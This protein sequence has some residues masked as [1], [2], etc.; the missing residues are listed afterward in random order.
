MTIQGLN[1]ERLLQISKR[2]NWRVEDIIGRDKAMD[3]TKPFLPESFARTGALDF[4]DAA[5]R[6]KLN[7]IAASAISP[8]SSW[9]SAASC[10]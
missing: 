10:R 6:L 3:F 9:S 7:Q 1:Y 2:V 8:C 4:L 5:E